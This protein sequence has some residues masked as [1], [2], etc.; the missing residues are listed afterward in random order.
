MPKYEENKEVDD[1]YSDNFN[2]SLEEDDEISEAEEGFMV[3]YNEDDF[4]KEC[5]NCKNL[6]DDNFIQHELNNKKYGFCSKKCLR[7]F[8]KSQA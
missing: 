7:E 2:E 1:V 5:E 8:L 3:G 4:V 6:L